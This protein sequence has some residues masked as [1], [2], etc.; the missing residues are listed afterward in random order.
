MAI[1]DYG[2]EKTISLNLLEYGKGVFILKTTT[3]GTNHTFIRVV[4]E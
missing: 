1:I 3:E 4:V 2:K